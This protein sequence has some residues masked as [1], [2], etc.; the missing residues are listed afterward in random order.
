MNSVIPKHRNFLKNILFLIFPIALT[1]LSSKVVNDK[2]NSPQF[3]YA[4]F[5]SNLS[6]LIYTCAYFAGNIPVS[7]WI[8]YHIPN[9]SYNQLKYNQGYSSTYFGLPLLISN[10]ISIIFSILFITK[11]DSTEDSTKD[12]ITIKNKQLFYWIIGTNTVYIT[13]IILNQSNWKNSFFTHSEGTSIVSPTRIP[14]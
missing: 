8:Q 7:R 14:P 5:L 3:L 9:D 4:I 2:T 6:S 12:P 13:F 10:I 11:D 1:I